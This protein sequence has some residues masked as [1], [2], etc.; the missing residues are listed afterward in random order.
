[1]KHYIANK[2]VEDIL[3]NADLLSKFK[4]LRVGE[5]LSQEHKDI[6]HALVMKYIDA[7]ETPYDADFRN[8]W[9]V[10]DFLPYIKNVISA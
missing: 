3:F 7:W 1:M 2:I 10:R 9:S 6:V 5:I 8:S 4:T